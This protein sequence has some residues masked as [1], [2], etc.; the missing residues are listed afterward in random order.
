MDPTLHWA[1][2]PAGIEGRD[3]CSAFAATP[4]PYTGPIPL[5]A[6]LHGAHVSEESGGYPEAWTLPAAADIPA[7]FANVGSFYDQFR[8]EA[9]ERFGTIWT[10]TRPRTNTRTIKAQPRCGTTT[11]PSA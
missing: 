2:P 11:T 7:G 8:E 10:P 4:P 1:N 3:S 6:H 9:A 5:V